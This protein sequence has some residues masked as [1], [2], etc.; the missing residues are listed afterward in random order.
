M[1]SVPIYLKNMNK[2]KIREQLSIIFKYT[3]TLLLESQGTFKRIL[4]YLQ[5]IFTSIDLPLKNIVIFDM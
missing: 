2:F 1:N 5:S 3:T 4:K